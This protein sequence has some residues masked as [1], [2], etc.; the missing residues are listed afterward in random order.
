MGTA[1]ADLGGPYFAPGGPDAV[2]CLHGFTSTPYEVRPL[3]EALAAEGLAVLAPRLAG[4]GR[5]A[6][7]LAHCRWPDWLASAKLAFARLAA[8]HERIFVVG[9]SMGALLAL[10]LAHD[11]GAR[12]AG[13][14]AMATP[15]HFGL[16]TQTYLR[17]VESVALTDLIP[18]VR[19]H[20]GPD[21]SDSA[22]AAAMPGYVRIPI[23]A[24][25]SLLEG[26]RQVR[27]RAPQLGMPVLILHGRNDHTASVANAYHLHELLRTP[28]RA[29]KI[30]PRSW[31]ILPLDVEHAE[32]IE[33]VLQFVRRHRSDRRETA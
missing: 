15:L 5:R 27:Q 19:K 23:R 25:A 13:V 8:H 32:V 11:Q 1:T 7:E 3:A 12:V 16:A 20:Q 4:H 31:H 22:V 6:E 18:F 24:A 30:Y 17:L 33:D 21:V 29:L 14:V 10:V 28:D 26:Q 2:L 9:T